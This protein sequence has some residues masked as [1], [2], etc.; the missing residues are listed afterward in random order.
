MAACRE[1][2]GGVDGNAVLPLYLPTD[3]GTG[4]LVELLTST[5]PAYE[6]DRVALVEAVI[7][8]SEDETLL[9]R[10]LSGEQLDPAT[11]AAD[12]HTAVGRGHFHPVVPVCAATDQ[13]LTR[14]A[15]ADRAGLSDTDRA[16][17]ADRLDADRRPRP[18]AGLRPG[19][20]AGRRGG[21]HLGGPVPGPAVAGAGVLRDD[22]LR[23][24]AA[25]VR[26]R[27]GRP[28]PSGP[29]RR[30]EDRDPDGRRA[31]PDRVGDRRRAVRGGPAGQRRDRRRAVRAAAAAGDPALATARAAAADRGARRP[32]ATTRTAWPRRSAGCRRQT[33]RCGSSATPTPASWCS[34]AWAR[35]TATW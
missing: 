28:R 23:H 8:E 5:D 13:G 33:R 32:P 22:P 1:A 10:Y 34:G 31:Q 15:D 21:A 17:A 2:F 25:R 3:G 7:A 12:L 30:R 20:P 26:P 9:D 4:P 35:R 27:R 24:R 11:L 16:S 18:G 14:A 29:R 6:A 19:R